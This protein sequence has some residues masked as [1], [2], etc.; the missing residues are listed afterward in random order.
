[1]S[2]WPIVRVVD[3]CVRRPWSVVVLAAALA[4]AGGAYTARHF[5]IDSDVHHL[6]SSDVPWA[7][8][9]LDYLKDF[10]R[11]GIL[12]VVTASTPEAADEAT[13]RLAD[14]LR[15][16]PERFRTVT[17][18][19]SGSFFDQ[20]GL[21][22]LPV[23]D[24]ERIADGLGQADPLIGTLAADQSLRGALD[25][26]ALGLV[27][28]R[29]GETDLADLV[30]PMNMAADAADAA[31]AGRA[32]TFS[33]QMLINDNPSAARDLRRF[34]LIDPV[35]DFSGMQPGRSATDAITRTVT[36]LGIESVPGVRVRLTGEIPIADDEFGTVAKNA[37]LNA[38]ATVIAVV[39]ILWMALG[40]FRLILAVVVSLFAGL[41][42]ATA[43]GLFLVG[44]LNLISV[45]FFV[46]FVGL[47]VD[48]GIQF[49]VRYRAERHDHPDLRDALRS[50]AGKA[51]GPLAL[52]AIATAVGFSSFL[53]TAYRGLSELGEIAGLGMIIAFAASVT[54][55]PALISL[56]NPSGE[57]RNIGFTALAP[58]DRFLERH[59][60][61]IVVLTL[62]IVVAASPLLFFLP[63]DFNPM[64]LRSMQ[65]DSVATYE[66]LRGEP[67]LGANAIDLV[68]PDLASAQAA[69]E[70]LSALP[71]VAQAQTLADLV[72][73]DQDQKLKLIQDA[74][75]AIDPSLNP[76]D[77][78]P[79]PS[80]QEN[81]E[82]LSLT[83]ADLAKAAGNDQG[84]GPD[85]A[86][87]LSGLLTRLAQADPT[88]RSRLEAAIVEPLRISLD[89]LR[90]EL[91]ATQ[92]VS[93]DEMPPELVREWMTADG[94]ARVQ[95]L[96]KGDPDDT[97]NL[98]NFVN[99]VLA[100]APTATGPAVEIVEAG[101]TIVHAFIEAGAFALAA[102][103]VL[104]LITLRRFGDVLLTLIPLIVAGAVTLELCVVFDF[105]LNFA[106]IIALPLL[107]GVGVAFKI[108]YIVA[109]RSGKT[110]LLQSSLT[111]AV[112]F[113]AMT[114]ATAFG[115][116][117]LSSHP[118]TSSMGRLMALALICTMAAAVLF[119]PVLMGPPRKPA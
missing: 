44:A 55:L 21:L 64:H 93:I 95:V 87:R 65:V 71:Q 12:V 82:A 35:L 34:L 111:R 39:L 60:I 112:L 66:E 38:T 88:V 53:P 33:W 2:T 1:M 108:Y 42:V 47:G 8:R 70:K 40:S 29:R 98:R 43:A 100:V 110:G 96:P 11:A 76:D 99:A 109:W 102:I 58:V 73:R 6:I 57:P 17:Q 107:L 51:G 9:A 83:A 23:A 79:A 5:A 54:V 94:R 103:F 91:K 80:D 97:T 45:A 50:A 36:R 74:A 24:V 37:A 89:R 26:L 106:N 30:R 78:R 101:N 104:L 113:S 75:T 25:A 118:G 63:F 7:H 115:S 52:A 41:V 67:L 46:L 13:G 86:R 85:A 16:E 31:L 68:T 48:F 14:A 27:G 4:V 49:C 18:P 20:N 3:F 19:G 72:P 15:Q 105:P 59:R 77:V 10:P 84:P 81:I 61:P 114:T 69:A 92:P 32:I 22:F 90:N 117:W 62:L 116:L 56:L 28:V 119:Q